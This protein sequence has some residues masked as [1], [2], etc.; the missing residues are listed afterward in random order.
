MNR[1]DRI[2]LIKSYLKRLG[3]GEDLNTVRKE[4][5]ENLSTYLEQKNTNLTKA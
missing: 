5:V 4:F 1:E 3:S 2:N